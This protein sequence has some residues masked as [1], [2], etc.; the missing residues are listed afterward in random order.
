MNGRTNI[1]S[2]CTT[3]PLQVPPAPGNGNHRGAHEEIIASAENRTYRPKAPAA[4]AGLKQ[5]VKTMPR[6]P[7]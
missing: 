5:G 6:E 7:P 3:C 2:I 4:Q 1:S